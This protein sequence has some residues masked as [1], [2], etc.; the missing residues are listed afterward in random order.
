MKSIH[1]AVVA[2]VTAQ[3]AFANLAQAYSLE[4]SVTSKA[5]IKS[6]NVNANNG[7]NGNSGNSGNNGNGNSGN[8]DHGNSTPGDTN[9]NGNGQ[10]DQTG[11]HNDNNDHN[12]N[13]NGNNTG[14]NGNG[15]GNNCSG[16]QGNSANVGCANGDHDHGGGGDDG[17]GD[18]GGGDNGGGDNGGG[19]N[20]GGDNGGGDNG[21]G[22][23]GG[24]GSTS[25]PTV[26]LEYKVK[27]LGLF[28]YDAITRI[29]NLTPEINDASAVNILDLEK[30]EKGF[31]VQK[32]WTV[33]GGLGAQA[34]FYFS[35]ATG[36]QNLLGFSIGLAPQKNKSALFTYFV[37]DT[38][39]L[40]LIKRHIPWKAEDLYEWSVGD[41]VAY[42]SAGGMIFVA[43]A[44]I[45]FLK[46][47]TTIA[48]QGSWRYYVQKID[49]ERVYVNATR[50]ETKSAA[51]F[52]GTLALSVGE[53]ALKD[54]GHGFS[55][56]IDLSD[57]E[58][59]RAY[60][61]MLKGNIVPLQKMAADSLNPFV[62]T[63]QAN[64]NLLSGKMKGFVFGIP[65]ANV[66]TSKANFYSLSNIKNLKEGLVVNNEYGIYSREVIGRLV[67]HHK[68]RI[69]SFYGGVT[70]VTDKNDKLISVDNKVHFNWFFEKDHSDSK[71]LNHAIEDVIQDTGL[72]YLQIKAPASSELGYVSVNLKVEADTHFTKALT[73][74]NRA[75]VFSGM[76]KNM[77]GLIDLYFKA[78]DR[79]DLCVT[80]EQDCKSRYT[81]E[82]I[83]AI[84]KIKE[85]SEA[86]SANF[87][88]DNKAFAQAY[89]KIGEQAWTNQFVFRAFLDQM[90]FCGSNVSYEVSGEKISN[91]Q[92]QNITSLDVIK[93]K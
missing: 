33:L 39:E 20:G 63:V 78:G 24:G 50:A 67:T 30:Y 56:E 85:L 43:G 6:I 13:G 73:G 74:A 15:V 19:D 10:H 45:P 5:V 93:C 11:N 25:K 62:Q 89:A 29:F 86:L 44:G 35:N 60:E 4:S 22:D 42:E 12:P 91:Y 76:Q 31:K 75:A 46:A 14:N 28:Y 90:R 18:D 57:F 1:L 65:F 16:N 87:G 27:P 66:T 81:A 41:S 71:A 64:A 77:A 51:A 68:N 2:T 59:A 92:L 82:S 54:V 70:K 36:L 88:K 49:D 37:K 61:D 17:G 53:A 80:D 47:N 69:K 84:G 52:A 21:G 7:N 79:H 9:N 34:Q 23:N 8:S 38:K 83:R 72:D 58:A 40:N 32:F 48:T 26:Q 3:V 55:Y